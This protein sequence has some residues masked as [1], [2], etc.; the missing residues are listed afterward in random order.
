M[1]APVLFSE[2]SS[3]PVLS[4]LCGVNNGGCSHICLQLDQNTHVCLCPEGMEIERHNG[5][6]NET[7]SC[8]GEEE[9]K[10]GVCTS[11]THST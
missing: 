8:P 5:G 10:N 2:L 11:G 1:N 6:L 3:F 9:M 4:D 7:C